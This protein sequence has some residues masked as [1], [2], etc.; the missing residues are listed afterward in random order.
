MGWEFPYV[1]TQDSDFAFDFG[2]TLTEEQAQQI[3]KLQEMIDDPREWLQEWSGQIGAELK[4]G[5][6][7]NPS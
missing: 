3:P 7:E 1:S 5:L 6:R 2:S 4:D